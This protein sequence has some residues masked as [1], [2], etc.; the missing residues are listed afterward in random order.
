[1]AKIIPI[2]QLD[3]GYQSS[4]SDWQQFLNCW[5]ARQADFAK[6]QG[7]S[8]IPE[9]SGLDVDDPIRIKLIQSEIAHIEKRIGLKLPKSYRD[10]LEAGGGN[11]R[12]DADES[13]EYTDYFLPLGKIGWFH[14]VFPDIH[15][16]IT[17]HDHF[18]FYSPDDKYY[19]YEDGSDH[20]LTGRDRY[21]H[22]ILA[23]GSIQGEGVLLLNPNEI[24]AD[25]E[26][27]AWIHYWDGTERH[28]SFAKLARNVF[29]EAA[30][31]P[32]RNT[33]PISDANLRET[34]AKHLVPRKTGLSTQTQP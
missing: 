7:R 21:L 27:E 32:P 3:S 10:F 15:K 2:Q 28:L 14:E 13:G 30:F 6:E 19:R 29:L 26:W 8:Y 25:G 12:F 20:A 1:V 17:S 11:F 23:V 34:C 16:T 5:A 24:T 18:G 4:V 31:Q 22:R 33:W 9:L